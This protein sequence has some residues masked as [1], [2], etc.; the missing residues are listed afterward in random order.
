MSTRHMYTTTCRTNHWGHRAHHPSYFL[1]QTNVTNVTRATSMPL[2]PG[3]PC[4]E[5]L[6]RKMAN[7]LQGHTV[8]GMLGLR[9]SSLASV[10]G[11]CLRKEFCKRQIMLLRQVSGIAI[12]RRHLPKMDIASRRQG[13]CGMI[14]F[15]SH[16]R[17]LWVMQCTSWMSSLP[18]TASPCTL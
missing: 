13:G 17:T 18:K 5:R 2:A 1:A 3:F 7:L 10:H 14:H 9:I 8:A 16:F 11:V 6:C 15:I 4:D 12:M